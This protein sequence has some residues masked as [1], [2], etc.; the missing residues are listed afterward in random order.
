[1]DLASVKGDL[2]DLEPQFPLG[3]IDLYLVSFFLSE[4]AL[5]DRACDQVMSGVVIFVSSADQRKLFLVP[6]VKIFDR[7]GGPEGYRKKL[8]MRIFDMSHT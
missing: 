2:Q 6:V 1:M 3:D 7:H 8:R 4:Q 5:S